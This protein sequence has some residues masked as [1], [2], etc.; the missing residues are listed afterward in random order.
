MAAI[1]VWTTLPSGRIGRK[2]ARQLIREKLA[3]CVSVGGPV[4]SVYRWKGKIE[5]IH[6]TLLTIKTSRRVYP[7]LEKKLR[8]I[9]PYE[10]PEI[11]AVPVARCAEKYLNWIEDSVK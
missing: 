2:I 7:K 8:E 5:S 11:I 3:A 1:V 10:S 4:E 9:H 6:E